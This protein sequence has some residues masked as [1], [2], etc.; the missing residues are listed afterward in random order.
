MYTNP[1]TISTNTKKSESL[2]KN[3]LY[4]YTKKPVIVMLSDSELLYRFNL[5]FIFA[6]IHPYDAALNIGC[7]KI[8]PLLL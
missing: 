5:T 1:S 7:D 2:T 3:N 6:S 8:F 4:L